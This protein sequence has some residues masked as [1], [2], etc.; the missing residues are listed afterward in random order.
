MQHQQLQHRYQAIHPRFHLY[1]Q[2]HVQLNNLLH[3]V[4]GKRAGTGV[5]KIKEN[6][7]LALNIMNLLPSPFPHP[8]SCLETHKM[9]F[10]TAWE[11]NTVIFLPCCAVSKVIEPS[12][13][14]P[15]LSSHVQSLFAKQD[16]TVENFLS[17]LRSR[18]SYKVG[19]IATC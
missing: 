14:Y 13:M 2:L 12:S 18:F 6:V 11:Q 10:K 8:L 9:N 3:S 16:L 1:D 15:T 5:V 7:K 4:M 17:Q 19:A